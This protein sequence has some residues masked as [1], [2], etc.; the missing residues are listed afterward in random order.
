[1]GAVCFTHVSYLTYETHVLAEHDQTWHETNM[2]V[3]ESHCFIREPGALY[4]MGPRSR[5]HSWVIRYISAHPTLLL[6]VA[7]NASKIVQNH[8]NAKKDWIGQKKIRQP[9]FH[10]LAPVEKEKPVKGQELQGAETKRFI[11]VLHCLQ[12]SIEIQSFGLNR[13]GQGPW[14][15]TEK[16][17]EAVACEDCADLLVFL[18]LRTHI[19]D[20]LQTCDRR[21]N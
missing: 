12:N 1:M 4:C 8:L 16:W 14:N 5:Y 21:S 2:T 13:D 3:L 17:I 11:Q 20:L 7:R 18:C 6:G 9:R 10:S 15:K 19:T